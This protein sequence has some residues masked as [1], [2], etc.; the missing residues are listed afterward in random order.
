MSQKIAQPL[1]YTAAETQK[2]AKLIL[3]ATV[4]D[5]FS[6]YADQNFFTHVPKTKRII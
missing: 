5:H 1:S 2:F 6:H 4:L 3:H